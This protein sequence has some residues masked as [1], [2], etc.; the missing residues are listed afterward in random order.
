MCCL[1]YTRSVC[2]LLRLLRLVNVA[3]CNIL[4]ATGPLVKSRA[5]ARW[6]GAH[7]AAR[8][9]AVAAAAGGRSRRAVASQHFSSR[10]R[11]AAA[12]SRFVSR[13]SRAPG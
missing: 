4:F 7:A 2:C 6:C 3:V 12:H 1:C 8:L 5:K 11:H 9:A 10:R 13:L